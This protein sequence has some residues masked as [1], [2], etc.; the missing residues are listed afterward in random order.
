VDCRKKCGHTP[1]FTCYPLAEFSTA[2]DIRTCA[3]LGRFFLC[4]CHQS[5]SQT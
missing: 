4:I 2:G 5:D 1:V 3:Y